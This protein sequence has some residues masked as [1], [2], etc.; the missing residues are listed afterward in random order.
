[1]AGLGGAVGDIFSGFG[2]MASASAYSTASKLS[3]ESADITKRSTAIQEQ[4]Q[5]IQTYKAIGTEEAQ[6]AA[7]GFDTGS[8]SAGDL[9]R[10]SAS[11]AALSKQLIES[12][13][14]ITEKGY[15]EQGVAY[16]G[17]EKASNMQA[18]GDF[19]GG[20][21][22]IAGW[23]ICTEL[24]AQRRLPR[25]YWMPGAAIFASYPD[26]VQEGYYVWAVPSVRHLRLHPYSRYSRL[27]C[28]IFNW[29]AENIAAHA[30]VRGA[31][32]LVRGALVTACLWPMCWV[33]GAARLA[34]KRTTNWKG[35]YNAG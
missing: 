5:N 11:Q 6:T 13:G 1:M 7:A 27:L 24:V 28:A 35:L 26:A 15:E 21:L 31:R 12:Q 29:R 2:A 14:E 19:L 10:S 4:Q 23:V 33:L 18:T 17:Q 9:M 25:R 16:K 30:G 34:L 8:G 3:Y 20:A 22:S 32:V